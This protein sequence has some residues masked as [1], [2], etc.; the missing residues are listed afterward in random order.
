[1]ELKVIVIG[2][3]LGWCG[4]SVLVALIVSRAIRRIKDLERR[5]INARR[6]F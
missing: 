1:M 6:D 5:N 3:I 2:F 4:I